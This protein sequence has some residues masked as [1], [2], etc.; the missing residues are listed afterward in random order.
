MLTPQ[1][2][3]VREDKAWALLRHGHA[4]EALALLK[5]ASDGS[6]EL[7]VTL[8]YGAALMWV[9]QYNAAAE[10]F[11]AIIQTSRLEKLPMMLSENHYAL[12]G[13]GRW[14]LGDLSGAIELWR[15]GMMAP[16]AT[17]GVCLQCPLLLVLASILEPQLLGLDGAPDLLKE[18]SRDPRL[19][20]FPGT[21]A[22]FVVGTIDL[23]VLQS[24]V[25]REGARHAKCLNRDRKW[26]VAFYSAVLDAQRSKTAERSS[27]RL[28]ESITDPRQFDDLDR[29][30]FWWLTRCAEYYIAKHV[31]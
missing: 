25:A 9:G 7:R 28:V 17:Y 11:E 19:R 2:E 1:Q 18:R 15:L 14:C 31:K 12:G 5:D 16:Y 8:G 4:E 26:R 23:A 27:K 24:S 29:T 30:E 21:L 22:Q 10:H 13:A 3:Q 6:R 20:G